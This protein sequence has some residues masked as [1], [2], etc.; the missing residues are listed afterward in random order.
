[1]IS[2]E[3]LKKTIR[4]G[5]RFGKRIQIQERCAEKLYSQELDFIDMETPMLDEAQLV[6][7]LGC[8][9][10]SSLQTLSAKTA[11]RAA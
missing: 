2:L 8:L 5:R 3:C 6:V 4:W 7:T 11:Y 10:Y 9:R 1:L